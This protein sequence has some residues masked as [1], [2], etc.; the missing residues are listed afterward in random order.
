MAFTFSLGDS[1]RTFEKKPRKAEISFPD[2]FWFDLEANARSLEKK[3]SL[4]I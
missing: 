4:A 2:Q 1:M 3:P